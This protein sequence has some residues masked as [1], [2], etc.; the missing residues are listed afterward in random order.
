MRNISLILVLTLL[1]GVTS[2]QQ[3]KMVKDGYQV[4]RYPNGTVSSEGYFKNGK[5][6]GF[7]KSF[8]VTGI[9]KSEGKYTAFLL[10]S[11]WLFFDQTGD[12]L[13]KINYLYGKKNGWSYKYKKDPSAGLYIWSKELFAGD[14]KEGTAYVYFPEGKVQQTLTY[15]KGKKEGLSKEFDRDGNIISLLEYRSDYLVNRERINRI[16]NKGMKQGDW[17]EFYPNGNIR[18][19][20]TYRDDLMHGYY[21]EYDSRGNLTLTMLYDNGAIVKSNVEDQPDIEIVNKYDNDGKLIYSGPYREKVPVGVHREFDKDGKI[22]NASIYNDNGVMVSQGL[23]DAEGRYN[24]RWKDFFAD[25][26]VRDEGQYTDSRRTGVWK[27]YN[28]SGKVEQTGAYNNG[29]PDGLWTWY[30]ENGQIIRE[31]EYFQGRRDGSYTEYSPDGQVIAKGTY[32]D[33]EKNGDWKY[34]TGDNTEEGKY[35]V[36][37]RDGLWKSFYPDGTVRFKGSFIQGNPDGTH[38]YYYESG[39]T[40]EEQFYKNGLREKTWKKYDEEGNQLLTIG[41]RNDVE[42]NIN[43]VKIKLP[44]SDTKLIK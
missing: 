1:C 20:I 14:K 7:W 25:G 40:K 10:D 33:D 9:I 6:D 2:A 26:K 5:P 38:F 4:F 22:I 37:L 8:Y 13:E 35:L 29:R 16:D 17:K 15:N 39:K 18:K 23:V 19:E 28:E 12:T 3:N 34:K 31:E 42:V 30:Y 21:K 11:V 36:G 24:G 32:T 44:E 41:Y 27:F 43:G